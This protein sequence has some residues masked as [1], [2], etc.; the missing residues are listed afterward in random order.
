LR[1]D[2]FMLPIL[3]ALLLLILQGPSSIEKM[4]L[5]G[6]LPAALEAINRQMEAQDHR[7]SAIERADEAVLATLLAIGGDPDLS[8]ALFKLLALDQSAD[9]VDRPVP[10]PS[11]VA[12][13]CQAFQTDETSALPVVSIE[14]Q[15]SRDGPR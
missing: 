2:I 10:E 6:R 5:D 13:E 9:S 12:D 1:Y 11:D 3:P 15:R 4:A 14:S 7:L 8:H